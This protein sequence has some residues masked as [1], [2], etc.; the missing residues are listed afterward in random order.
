MAH[1]EE[2]GGDKKNIAVELN[3]VPFIDL[4]SVC[5]IF[6]LITAVWT[7]ISM[8]QLGSSLYAK[9]TEASPLEEPPPYANIP[10]RVNVL[11]TGFN[12][13]IGKERIDIPKS[14]SNYNEKALLKEIKKIKD[15]Y[16]EKKDVIVA[17]RD[18]V[19]YEYVVAAMDALLNGG[20]PEVVIATGEML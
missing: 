15:I 16:P 14:G 20:F 19:K 13:M 2:M 10:F 12:I 17:S 5:I 3:L 8:I 6:L 18:T 11:E 4:M 9:K 7:Q 1:V